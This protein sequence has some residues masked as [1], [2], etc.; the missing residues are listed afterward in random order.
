M[1]QDASGRQVWID[2]ARGIGISLVVLAHMSIPP[3][4]TQYIC[5]F[6]MPLFFFLSGLL[7]KRRPFAEVLAR[8]ARTLLAPYLLFSLMA[9]AVDDVVLVNF[10]QGM[11]HYGRQLLGIV[12]AA[13]DGPYPLAVFP[14]WF[15]ISLFAAQV[16]FSCVLSISRQHPVRA[17]ALVSILAAIG[18]IN[19]RTTRLAVPWSVTTSLIGL[20]FLAVGDRARQ[21]VAGWT[22]LTSGASLTAVVLLAGAVG[23]AANL[24][25]PV[26]MAHDSYG[27]IP[28][29]LFGAL[30]GI[31]MTL[32]LGMLLERLYHL[33]A[34]LPGAA[35]VAAGGRRVAR[36][37]IGGMTTCLTYLGRNALI[38]LP[39]HVLAPALAEH[40]LAWIL[41][42]LNPIFAG[43]MHKLLAGLILLASIELLRRCPLIVPRK[44]IRAV[45]VVSQAPQT[46]GLPSSASAN[47]TGR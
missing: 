37:S 32:L 4:L 1:A 46:A 6:H 34:P 47:V 2:I 9:L 25:D 24:N 41:P 35:P 11:A 12:Y 45:A 26:I 15:L 14:L 43:A 23:I 44:S 40:W 31:A 28:L 42:L 21:W 19:S 10:Y 18:F 29:F 30:C 20:L 17:L 39:M 5:A 22:S 8:R 27:S 36:A 7:Y 13:A 38:I 33:T 16:I 3:G